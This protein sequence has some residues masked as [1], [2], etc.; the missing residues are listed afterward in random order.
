MKKILAYI[1]PLIIVFFLFLFHFV[2]SISYVG[3]SEVSAIL[4]V[5]FATISTFLLFI[6]YLLIS[7]G[8]KM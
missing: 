4:V 6:I 3:G 5:G 8:R 1:F 2:N 7:G